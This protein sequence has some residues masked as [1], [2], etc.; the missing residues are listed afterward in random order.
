MTSKGYLFSKTRTELKDSV[1]KF[2]PETVV[3]N[4]FDFEYD[5]A[6]YQHISGKKFQLLWVVHH[7]ESIPILSLTD[8][9]SIKENCIYIRHND[10]TREE[11]HNQIQALINKR[12]TRSMQTPKSR[13]LNEHLS[14]LEA[15]C[16]R[17]SVHHSLLELFDPIHPMQRF[18][19]FS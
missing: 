19:K 3:Y 13:K 4:I 14:E 9:A 6:E 15:L 17:K 1:Q 11:N 12:I 8:G 2:L 5:A 16:R 10:S 7:D 18:Y